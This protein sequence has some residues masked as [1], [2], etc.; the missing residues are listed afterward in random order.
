MEENEKIKA[1]K[2]ISERREEDKNQENTQ[3]KA[4][5][6]EDINI[7]FQKTLRNTMSAFFLSLICTII[8]FIC[9]IPLLRMVS[10]DSYGIVKVHFELAFTLINFIPLET[11]HRASQKSFP[12]KNQ[13]KEKYMIISQINYVFFCFDLMVSVIVFF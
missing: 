8:N 9:N 1:K 2:D 4:M 7:Y 13:E 3:I 10:K 11:I 12:D 6:K 5:E